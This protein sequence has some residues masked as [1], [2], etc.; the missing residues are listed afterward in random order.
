VGVV[1]VIR[2]RGGTST[3]RVVNRAVGWGLIDQGL[4]SGSN[5]VLGMVIARSTTAR[6]FGTF[7]VIYVVYMLAMGAARAFAYEPL[8][9]RFSGTDSEIA[10][11]AARSSLAAS[12][13]GGA[14]L[15]APAVVVGIALGGHAGP[16]LLAMGIALPFLLLQDS[17]RGVCFALDRARMAAASDTIWL[18]LQVVGFA[19]VLSADGSPAAWLLLAVWTASGS[20]AGIVTCAWLRLAPVGSTRLWFSENRSLIGASFANFAFRAAP[21]YLVYALL[22]VVGGLEA[23]GRLRAAYLVFGP[24]GVVFEGAV[25]AALPAAVAATRRGDALRPLAVRFSAALTALALGWGL[26][27]A[28]TPGSIGRLALGDNWSGAAST[29]AVL[30]FS[31]VAEAVLVGAAVALRARGDQARLARARLVA[32]PV[33]ILGSL[34]LAIPFGAP[35]AAGGFVLGDATVSLAAWRSLGRAGVTDTLTADDLAIAP[36][37]L[38]EAVRA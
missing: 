7:S 23:L 35:G 8:T 27:I 37:A 10:G 5:F 16:L 2:R 4:N 17:V 20:V 34:G 1:P 26:V 6:E 30:T 15:G 38:A 21:P 13:A 33:T 19:V 25:L 22:P 14:V 11:P 36:D 32:G 31:L 3:G 28:V 29:R 18:V 9:V 12:V 24:V